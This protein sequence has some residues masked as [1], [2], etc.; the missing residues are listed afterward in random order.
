VKRSLYYEAIAALKKCLSLEPTNLTALMALAVSFTN[1]SYQAQACQVM[2]QKFI[3]LS[4]F[5][6]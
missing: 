3:L 6:M 2:V 1:E 4:E 5:K